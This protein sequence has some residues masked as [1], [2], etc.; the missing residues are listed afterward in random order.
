MVGEMRPV[1]FQPEISLKRR[2]G[3]I[4]TK[5]CPLGCFFEHLLFVHAYCIIPEEIGHVI[6]ILEPERQEERDQFQ[7]AF[8]PDPE[9]YLFTLIH[10][11]IT[12]FDNSN[13]V[14]SDGKRG[15]V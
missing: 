8:F 5:E 14:Y 13:T 3:I 7:V 15:K 6:D 1:G 11:A 10:P 4:K 2:T 9:Y 12:S